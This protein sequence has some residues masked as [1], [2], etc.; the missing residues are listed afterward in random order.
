M[1]DPRPG[2]L[3][4]S[5]DSEAD[6][7]YLTLGAPDRRARTNEDECG[8][9]WRVSSDGRAKGVTVL[10]FHQHWSKRESELVKIL[11]N[12]LSVSS[13]IMKRELERAD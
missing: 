11:S 9:L 5:Y 3:R 13:R 1:T 6:V 10:A 7:L 8:L 12:R 4:L 2:D